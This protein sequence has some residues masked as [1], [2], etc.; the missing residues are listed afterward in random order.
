MGLG[1]QSS[2]SET[3]KQPFILLQNMITVLQNVINEYHNI[4]MLLLYRAFLI[5]SHLM[6]PR[7]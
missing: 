6:L 7:K 2:D 1:C 3:Q 5:S 4:S